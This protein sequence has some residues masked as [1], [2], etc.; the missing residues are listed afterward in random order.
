MEAASAITTKV[1]VMLLNVL[2]VVVLVILIL[3]A[4]NRW[5][6]EI[7]WVLGT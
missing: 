1:F 4:L 2:S 7:G 5:W 6:N 3:L